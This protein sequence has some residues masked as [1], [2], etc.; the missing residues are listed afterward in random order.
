MKQK[1]KVEWLRVGDSNSGYFHKVVK[2]RKVR[3]RIDSVCNSEGVRFEQDQVPN[4]FV[5]HFTSF[6]GQE[7]FSAPF[8]DNDLFN[9]TLD[10]I[11]ASHMVREVTAQEVK[12]CIF[13]MG[14]DKSPGPDGYSAAFFK[15]AWDIISED[16][17]LRRFRSFSL[18]ASCSKK[19]IIRV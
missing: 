5:N 1:A 8:E 6:L 10:P 4:A 18:M 3:S 7:G 9:T 14:D 12:E 16:M 2:S 17:L 19:L 11:V 15:G 13:S